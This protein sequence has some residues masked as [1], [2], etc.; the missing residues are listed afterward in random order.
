M[1]R[2]LLAVIAVGVVF[3]AGVS[4]AQEDAPQIPEKVQ[5]V[6][7]SLV[8]DWTLKATAGDIVQEGTMT[9][10]WAPGRQ[11]VVVTDSMGDQ[12]GSTYLVGWDGLS[13][14]GVVTYRVGMGG[15]HAIMCGR[16]V[17]DT[18]IES[19]NTV[20]VQ[21]QTMT[22]QSR[23]VKAGPDKFVFTSTKT[24]GD[25]SIVTWK[26]E[27]T[28]VKTDTPKL[29]PAME[30]LKGLVGDWVYEG[31]QANPPVAGLPYGGAGKYFGTYTTRFTLDGSFQETKIE[32][33]NPSGKTSSVTLTGFDP[34]SGK[35]TGNSFISDG[36]SSVATTTVDGRTWTTESTMTT[37]EGKKVRIRSVEKYS[38]NW[39]RYVSTQ[40]AS[41]DNG[42]TWKL[43]W[44]EEG[45]KVNR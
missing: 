31:E 45:R 43:W 28:R 23:T 7:D 24:V 34:K 26:G 3:S 4:F 11:Y 13:Q 39:S 42:K 21:G 30:K 38:S 14:D 35:Y 44:K 17:S 22:D 19:E 33:N 37:S 10:K 6:L 25:Q 1:R 8:G 5:A 15:F 18:V 27:Y 36:S 32:D 29:S 2:L 41:P 40:E 9:A 12:W 16:I 20:V